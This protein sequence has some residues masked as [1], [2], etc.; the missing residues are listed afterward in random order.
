MAIRRAVSAAARTGPWRG[1]FAVLCALSFA[2]LLAGV[3]GFLLAWEGKTQQEHSV[4]VVASLVLT[5][6]V[7]AATLLVA[8]E[9]ARLN[10]AS[11][12]LAEQLSAACCGSATERQA[13]CS[14]VQRAPVCFAV[15]N[16]F[17][18]ES[19]TVST[20]SLSVVLTAVGFGGNAL[21]SHLFE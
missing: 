5:E 19:G 11:A 17:I 14:D 13:F 4:Q 2:G 16:G 1:S 15:L 3:L 6:W 18:V 20:V 9:L 12:N 7:L 8:R 21:L 10:T